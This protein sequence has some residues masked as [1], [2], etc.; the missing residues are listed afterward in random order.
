VLVVVSLLT[1]APT[2]AQ[3][4]GLTFQT[5]QA[6]GAAEKLEATTPLPQ[7]LILIFTLVLLL[8]MIGLWIAFA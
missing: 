7:R 2:A 1:P 5:A 3:L 8:T 4:A 6:D